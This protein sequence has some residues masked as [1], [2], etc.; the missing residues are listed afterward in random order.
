MKKVEINYRYAK[1][2]VD[3]LEKSLESR[4]NTDF[5]SGMLRVWK[6]FLFEL[7]DHD[8]VGEYPH[9]SKCGAHDYDL[10][11]FPFEINCHNCKHLEQDGG[12]WVPYGSTSAQL[13]IN[14]YCM[15]PEIEGMEEDEYEKFAKKDHKDCKLWE[16]RL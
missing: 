8:M 6:E 13:P 10:Q 7:C 11:E 1:W 12:D 9:C 14:H 16:G 3:R 2:M 4:G 15:H 5:D